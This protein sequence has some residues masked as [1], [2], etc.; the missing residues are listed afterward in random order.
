MKPITA[1]CAL[2]VTFGLS[3]NT[4]HAGA[5]LGAYVDYDGWNTGTI[6]Q[7]NTDSVKPLAVINLFSGFDQTWNGGL[8]TQA[9]NIVSRNAAPMITW[10][11]STSVRPNANLFNEITTGQW[12]TYID[13]WIAGLKKWQANYAI[14]KRPTVLL[15]FAHEFN[16]NW[17]PWGNDP[18]GLKAAWRYVYNRFAQAGVTNVE[19]VWCANNAS[20]D[21]Y[22]NI[23]LYYPGDDVVQWTAL[24]GY[25]WGSNYSFSQWKTFAETFSLPYT[26]LVT[27]YPT[28]PVL[29]AE[30]ASAEPNDVP[31]LAY[32]M[33][34]N[35]SDAG[36]SKE[37]WV[38][39]MYTRILTEYPAIRAIAW[40]NT[41]KELSWA[42]NGAGNTGLTAYNSLI[43][44]SYY[45]G[46]FTPLT[47]TP[48][49]TTSKKGKRTTTTSATTS[50]ITASSA[51]SVDSVSPSDNS[52]TVAAQQ[53]ALNLSRLPP[54]V[55][56]KLLEREAQ[57]F[58][59]LPEQA[60]QALRASR[61]G[62]A[63]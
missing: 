19:W 47:T 8:A 56:D 48:T 63:E 53:R 62:M 7:F 35:D 50:T 17:Y 33:D 59:Q 26:Q 3:V 52:D 60:R 55:G 44:N 11:P 42:L 6:D 2:C 5:M 29:L 14:D 34:G 12:N 27:T 24:D 9:S 51:D 32:G 40:F 58:R 21:N 31:N 61:L 39:D 20:V 43:T 16:G 23:T 37:V 49:T 45:T 10:M 25:N 54:I 13:A 22:N 36:Q 38:Q 30:V 18:N 41:N 1:L 28:K 15:R 57:G 4:V 46:T